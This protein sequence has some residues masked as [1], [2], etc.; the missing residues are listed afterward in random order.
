MGDILTCQTT[1]LGPQSRRGAR[2]IFRPVGEGLRLL[3]RVFGEGSMMILE[4][5]KV[6]IIYRKMARCSIAA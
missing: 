2:S 5:C 3:H 1:G 6:F 4:I